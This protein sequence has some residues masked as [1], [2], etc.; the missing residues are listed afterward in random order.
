M[1]ME[2]LFDALPP[3]KAALTQHL[4]RA[5]YQAVYVWGQQLIADPILPEPNDWGWKMDQISNTW[6]P[7]WT[8]LPSMYAVNEL[9]KCG[10]KTNC[11]F[12]CK[13]SNAGVKCTTLCFCRGGCR[14]TM[15]QQQ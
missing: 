10:C 8:Q 2:K 15:D 12:N 5:I 6:D 13:C 4:K 9:V 1:E 11:T 14:A 3:T 7:I